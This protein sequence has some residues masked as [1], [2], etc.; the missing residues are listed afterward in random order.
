[1]AKRQVFSIAVL[2]LLSQLFQ[3]SA[4]LCTGGGSEE[5]ISGW[6]LQRHTYKTMKANLGHE[7]VFVCR[8][9][10]ICQSFNFVISIGV[11]EFNNRTKEARPKDFVADPDRYYYRRDLKRGKL[12]KWSSWAITYEGYEEKIK[13]REYTKLLALHQIYPNKL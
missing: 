9:D 3:K 4:C 11:C 5:S 8:Q 13:E 10:D 12:I 1:M 6:K 2:Y 7:C